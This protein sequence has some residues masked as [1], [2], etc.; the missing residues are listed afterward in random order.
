[1]AS[2]LLSSRRDGRSKPVL[3]VR[4]INPTF[5]TALD[6]AIH[7][8]QDGP[9]LRTIKSLHQP[10]IKQLRRF[11]LVLDTEPANNAILATIDFVKRNILSPIDEGESPMLVPSVFNQLD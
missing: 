4:S 7:S 3:L 8:R 2:G 10:L 6:A 9:A 5:L 1:M 11:R